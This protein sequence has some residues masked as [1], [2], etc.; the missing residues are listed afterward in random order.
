MPIQLQVSPQSQVLVPTSSACSCP[1]VVQCGAS[2]V[3][4]LLVSGRGQTRSP[5][6]P[7]SAST[8]ALIPP[9][10]CES[11]P[12]TAIS[13]SDHTIAPVAQRT[14]LVKH[15]RLPTSSL[16]LRNPEAHRHL[17]RPINS[18]TN[19][20]TH[21]A[22]CTLHSALTHNPKV[23]IRHLQRIVKRVG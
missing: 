9:Q 12:T 13:A 16:T 23:K 19:T 15:P 20:Y 10:H 21:S 14:I 8:P 4:P 11:L 22:L 17:T 6:N 2:M 1:L 5:F 7:M 18:P 3:Q